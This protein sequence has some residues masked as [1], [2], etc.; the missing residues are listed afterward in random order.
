MAQSG[1]PTTHVSA[2]RGGLKPYL[3]YIAGG[4][5]ALAAAVVIK[6][7]KKVE[8]GPKE[9]VAIPAKAVSHG[10]EG[11]AREVVATQPSEVTYKMQKGDTL[12]DVVYRKYKVNSTSVTKV[13]TLNN[14]QDVNNVPPGT[15]VI[16][17]VGGKVNHRSS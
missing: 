13:A 6:N 11:S 4:A 12:F 14:I 15:D 9:T 5:L 16:I 7:S 17:P 10:L 2:N 8:G 3:P 1:T